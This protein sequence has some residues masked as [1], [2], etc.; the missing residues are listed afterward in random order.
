[1]VIL[2]KQNVQPLDRVD[3]DKEEACLLIGFHGSQS[4]GP[5]LVPVKFVPMAGQG[6]RTDA[7]GFSHVPAEPTTTETPNK[8]GGI[9]RSLQ[10]LMPDERL[11]RRELEIVRYIA[12]GFANKQIAYQLNISEQTVK[13][14]IESIMRKL[15]AK[16][17]AHVV[18]LAIRQGLIPLWE[19]TCN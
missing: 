5:I 12:R 1:M 8:S 17:R 19:P 11:S 16:N 9:I 4:F 13:N 18:T 15:G 6:N 3:M 7:D 2:T 10:R 14:H